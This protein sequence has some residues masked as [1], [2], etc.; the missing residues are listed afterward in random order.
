MPP[1]GPSAQGT[2]RAR[3]PSRSPSRSPP[4]QRKRPGAASRF[5][6]TDREAARK[7]ALEKEQEEEK[8]AQQAAAS[9]GVHD[10]VKQH[11]NTVQQY[12]REFRKTDSKIKGLRSYNNWVK[13]STIQK[14]IGEERDLKILDMGC[15]KGS[16]RRLHPAGERSL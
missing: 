2:K 1:A 9:R 11:Y 8:V 7:R 13:S 5:T 15:G 4:R 12:G 10:V 14:F 3:S 16:R 6:V